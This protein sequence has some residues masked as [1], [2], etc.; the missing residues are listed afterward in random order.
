VHLEPKKI[1]YMGR[2]GSVYGSQ[3]Q[4]LSLAMRLDRRRYSPVVACIGG[5]ELAGQLG[6]HGIATVGDLRLRPTRK[7]LYIPYST[8][9]RYALLR[10]FR[11]ENIS[12]IHC[13]Y[14]WYNPYAVWLASKLGCPCV[15]HVRAPIDA[16]TVKTCKCDRADVV[17]A[18]SR[19]SARNVREAGIDD[20]KVRMIADSVDTAA[21]MPLADAR[22]RGRMALGLSERFVFGFVGRISSA[23]FA[24]EFIDAAAIVARQRPNAAFLLVGEVRDDEYGTELKELVERHGLGGRVIMAGHR[25]DMPAVLNCCD[26][27]VTMAGGS[28]MYEA[29]AC[30][31]PVLSAGFTKRLDSTH[32]LHDKTGVVLETRHPD[33]VAAAMVRL[34]DDDSYRKQLAAGSL[35][36]VLEHLTDSAM[37]TRTQALYD[38]LLPSSVRNAHSDAAG[39]IPA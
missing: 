38:E 27:L 18:I 23:K 37:V 19:R 39:V 14:L 2:G 34:M 36:H 1:L 11:H 6:E 7:F 21:F 31:V 3:R 8:L 9:D 24:G 20:G 16:R 30:G 5:G 12:L 17:V 10:R 4:L 28:V 35:R 13:S 29:M 26:V 32:V 15:V 22:A 33:E 25:N